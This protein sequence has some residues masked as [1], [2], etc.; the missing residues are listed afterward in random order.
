MSGKVELVFLSGNFFYTALGLL[1]IEQG[2]REL[3]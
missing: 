1:M 2:N 3:I